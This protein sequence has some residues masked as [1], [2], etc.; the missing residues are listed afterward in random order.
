M[1]PW[2]SSWPRTEP[3]SSTPLCRTAPTPTPRSRGPRSKPALP[4]RGSTRASFSRATV[5][6]GR[7]RTLVT[8][9]SATRC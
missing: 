5:Q 1:R 9:P 3:R 6:S 8:T 4:S 2:L 7:L